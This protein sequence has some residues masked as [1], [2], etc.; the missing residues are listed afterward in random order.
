MLRKI[1]KLTI[2]PDAESE[3]K[4]EHWVKK[5]IQSDDRNNARWQLA[6][7]Y[8]LYS[9]ILEQLGQGDK[10]EHTLRKAI[11]IDAICQSG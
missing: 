5:A 7:D 11:M 4:A 3:I 6:R 2:R 8:A 10:A 1:G 9:E